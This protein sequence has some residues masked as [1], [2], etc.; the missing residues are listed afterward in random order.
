MRAPFQLPSRR[1]LAKRRS[2]PV[3]RPT[4]PAM[5]GLRKSAFG[6]GAGDD[7]VLGGLDIGGDRFKEP[8]A[9]FGG[10]GAVIGEGRHS[11]GAGG[12][13]V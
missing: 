6:D 10:R 13:D 4:S 7:G 8:C 2:C 11:G 9:L 5:P 1:T 12:V 3:V